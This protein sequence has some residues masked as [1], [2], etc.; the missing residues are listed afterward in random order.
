MTATEGKHTDGRTFPK[1]QPAPTPHT[2]Y[3]VV[4]PTHV[5]EALS[6]LWDR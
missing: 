5:E 3:T 6:R 4:K 2:H 1:I